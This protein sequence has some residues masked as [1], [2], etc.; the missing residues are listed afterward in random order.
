MVDFSLKKCGRLR[1]KLLEKKITTKNEQQRK[2]AK[3]PNAITNMQITRAIAVD[4]CVCGRERFRVMDRGKFRPSAW[5]SATF[6]VGS[7]G[8]CSSPWLRPTHSPC[9]VAKTKAQS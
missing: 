6:Q 9:P 1:G 8:A 5:S 7:G 4:M 3:Y 2:T